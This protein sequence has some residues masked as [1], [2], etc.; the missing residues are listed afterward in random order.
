MS[1]EI[2]VGLTPN[3]SEVLLAS[4]QVCPNY[5][6]LGGDVAAMPLGTLG[7]TFS[8]AAEEFDLPDF[9]RYLNSEDS[10]LARL[11][12]SVLLGATIDPDLDSRY[13]ATTVNGNPGI[14]LNAPHIEAGLEAHMIG[15]AMWAHYLKAV[16]QSLPDALD[17]TFYAG[18]SR[19]RKAV[20]PVLNVMATSF[21]T[22]MV[23]GK[24]RIGDEKEREIVHGVHRSEVG[25]VATKLVELIRQQ[26]K[27]AV[28]TGLDLGKT[29]L[30][31]INDTNNSLAAGGF[32]NLRSR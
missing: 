9:V 21:T 2:W 28:R 22:A 32:F 3:G 5:G 29:P 1:R 18:D 7:V 23:G 25:G 31:L 19:W 12:E 30:K 8:Q 14:A 13:Y 20:D 26:I 4:A 27:D 16:R 15:V 24:S 6:L 17:H 10:A 11:P